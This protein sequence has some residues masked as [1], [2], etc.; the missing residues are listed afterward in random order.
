MR[1]PFGGYGSPASTSP[2]AGLFLLGI[3]AASIITIPVSSSNGTGGGPRGSR[4][5]SGFQWPWL[6][7][8]AIGGVLL[9][10]E[11]T[12]LFIVPFHSLMH[13]LLI[14]GSLAILTLAMT[15]ST[16]RYPGRI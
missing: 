16:R 5:P 10:F 8:V 6:A 13:P 4:Q 14:A 11:I 1:S 3:A 2:I 7:A 9:A 12:E 15:R